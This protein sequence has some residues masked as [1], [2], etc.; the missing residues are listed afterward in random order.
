MI[1]LPNS[2]F[3]HLLISRCKVI[4]TMGF[5]G[6]ASAKEPIYQCRR[7]KRCGFYPWVE[8]IPLEEGVVTHS[9]IFAWRV[10][11]AEEPGGL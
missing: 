10:P 9:S 11:W 4:V 8:K 5:P 1:R 7:L 2:L 3:L 6:G